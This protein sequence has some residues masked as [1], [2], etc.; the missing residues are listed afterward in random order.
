MNL[1]L[2]SVRRPVATITILLIILVIGAVSLFQTPLD[3]LPEIK[4]PY[5]AVIPFP[6]TSRRRT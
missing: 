5:L 4:P 3:L 1:P 6:G 2:L